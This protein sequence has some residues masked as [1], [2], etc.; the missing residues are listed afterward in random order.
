MYS[1]NTGPGLSLQPSSKGKYWVFYAVYFISKWLPWCN[2][3][4]RCLCGNRDIQ[5][6][7][8]WIKFKFC[9]GIL[10]TNNLPEDAIGAILTQLEC[11]HDLVQT[12]AD[13]WNQR[14]IVPNC[15]FCQNSDSFNMGVIQL[16]F[17]FSLCC[18][19]FA[20][21]TVNENSGNHQFHLL[22]FR[23]CVGVPPKCKYSVQN[24]AYMLH[25]S[26][27]LY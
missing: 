16:T 26:L 1:Y 21:Q 12:R 11:S 10:P 17:N 18:L 5:L 22:N 6:L 3:H 9:F 25:H 23:Y 27:A 24:L 8:K 4:V 19:Q 2:L 15:H 7:F 14:A 20:Y 13:D